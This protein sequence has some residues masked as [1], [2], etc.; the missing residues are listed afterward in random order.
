M[1]QLLRFI[2]F[3]FPFLITAQQQTSKV[4]SLLQVQAVLVSYDSINTTSKSYKT[5]VF[6]SYY[7]NKL[8]GRLTASGKRFN[9]TAY[10]AAHKKL[11][12]GTQV[13][14]TNPK[15][16]KFV[17]VT[18]TDRGPFSKGKEIDLTQRAFNEITHQKGL[19]V[20]KVDLEVLE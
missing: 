4:D 6:A 1:M 5:D 15:N 7:S 9:N 3:F 10:T 12:F 14:V 18:I 19:G 8:N 11:P 20:L 13:K 17:V 16:N 2:L